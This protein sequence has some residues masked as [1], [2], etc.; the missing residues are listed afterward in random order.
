MTVY[1]YTGKLTDYGGAPFPGARPSLFVT[2]QQAGFTNK[3]ALARKR[4]PVTVAPNGD[5]S[6]RLES[7]AAVK[8]EALYV[9]TCEWLGENGSPAESS[10]WAYFRAAVGGGNIGELAQSP[11]APWSISYGFGPPP[12]GFRGGLYIDIQGEK[13]VLYAPE[14]SRI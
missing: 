1:T 4:I 10:D 8:P 14:G 6:V 12:P 13:A 11:P 7:S 5:F 3:G 2:P 9:L